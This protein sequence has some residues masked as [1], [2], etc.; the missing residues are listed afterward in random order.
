M[1]LRSIGLLGFQF[2]KLPMLAASLF[3][4]LAGGTQ[5]DCSSPR[6]LHSRW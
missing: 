4:V 1:R 2:G 6:W 5:Q 3:V